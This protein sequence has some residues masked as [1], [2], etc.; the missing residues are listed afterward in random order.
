MNLKELYNKAD[1]KDNMGMCFK[2][3]CL[4]VMKDIPDKSIDMILCDLPYG[5]TKCKWDSIIPLDKLWEQYNRIIKDDG[6][7]CLTCTEPFTNLLI[8]NKPEQYKY[9]DL[10]WDKISTTG[11]LNAK[12]QPLRRHEQIL[13]FY[14]KQLH[15]FLLWK[16]EENKK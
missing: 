14:K 8:N 15:T 1:Y 16:L 13:C 10:V 6:M 5:T 4:E 12:R 7:I 9:Y 2:G 11:F 3:D